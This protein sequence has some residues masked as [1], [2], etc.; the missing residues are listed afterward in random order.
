MSKPLIG[1]TSYSRNDENRF[2]MP[3]NYAEAI[4]RAGGMPV[5]LV[6]STD[7]L[8]E[9][10]NR[11][12]GCVLTG[13]ADIAP[14][15]YKGK[16]KASIYGVNEERDSFELELT[17]YL[18]NDAIPTLAI[19]RGLQVLNVAMGG[20][21]IEHI[22]DEFGE[23]I[24]HRG[25]NY[26]KV[27]HSVKVNTESRLFQILQRPEFECPS[28]HHQS[29]RDLA[30]S[31]NSVANSD[32]GVIEAIESLNYPH[33]IAVQWHPETVADKDETQRKLFDTL[34]DWSKNGIFE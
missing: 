21:L 6:P 12:D 9:L 20:T 27:F 19:C 26:Q 30:P 17:Q 29:V 1:L 23:K 3:A 28:Y 25:E 8:R 11:L 7:N 31:F 22:P 34:V 18:V 10:I 16:N 32:D 14:D 13:G 33:V 4:Q 15:L 2:N 5:V 24:L